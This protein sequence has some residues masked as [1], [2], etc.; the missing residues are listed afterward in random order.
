MPCVY[1]SMPKGTSQAKATLNGEKIKLVAVELYWS[2]GI[3]QLVSYSGPS[4]IRTCW[5]L[6]C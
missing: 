3:R 5:A 1:Y 2:E 6:V 4:I